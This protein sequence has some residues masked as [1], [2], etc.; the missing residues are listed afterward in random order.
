MIDCDVRTCVGCRMCEVACSAHHFGAV[1]PGLARIR[2]AKLEEVGIDLAVVCLSCAEKPCLD[3]PTGALSLGAHGVIFLDAGL[4][5]ACETCVGA[6][7]IGAIGFFQGQPLLCDLCAGD[8]AC[9]RICPS[10]ALSY[11]EDYRE[12]PLAGYMPAH[13]NPGQRRAR[14][15]LAHGLP[16]RAC[17]KNGER[18]A[19]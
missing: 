1:S 10:Q 5:N 9:V 4:C 8:P 12:V 14:L 2:V 16:L 17:W 11:R 13:G 3:C 6:C 19:P 18:V 15:A 7:P